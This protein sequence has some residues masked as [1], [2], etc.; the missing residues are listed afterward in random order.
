VGPYA[1]LRAGAELAD[2][3][4]VG[5]YAE[6][7]NSRLGHG[8]R[9]GHFSYLGDARVGAGTNIGAG[10]ITCNYDG[11]TK[12][13]TIIGAGAF[14]G[15]DTML[16]APVSL[17]DGA[18]TGAGSV[19]TRDVAAGETVYGVPARPAP[20]RGRRAESGSPSEAAAEDV[21]LD[22]PRRHADR[23]SD[24]NADAL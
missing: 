12:H 9:M 5:N 4:H 22:G 17:G 21:A 13:E 20:R 11:R 7:K 18:R 6:I 2:G 10:T 24:T 19:V 1:H 16:V 23:D 15:S 14:V 3:V 8:V